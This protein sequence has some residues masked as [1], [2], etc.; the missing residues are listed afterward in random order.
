VGRFLVAAGERFPSVS[1]LL[2]FEF[3]PDY[4]EAARERLRGWLPSTEIRIEQGDFFSVDWSP[5]LRS[6]PDP[7]LVLGNPPWVTNA[8]LE[9]LG[10]SNLPL[11]SNTQQLRGI[12]AITG[13]S[14][15][16]ISEWMLIRELEWISDRD[17]ALAMLCKTAVAR[18]VLLHT[19]SHGQNP[20]TAAAYRIDA[21]SHFGA[22]VD[23]CLLV[24]CPGPRNGTH[25][26]RVYPN[27][28][29][30][31]PA[32][33]FGY[34]SGRLVADVAA[35]DR[36]AHLEG[37]DQFR[38]RSGIKHDCSK[39]MELTEDGGTYRN[40]MAEPVDIEDDYLFPMV[41]SADLARGPVSRPHRRML[42]TQR[43]VGEDTSSIRTRAPR[44]WKYLLDHADLLNR[45][46]SAVYRNRLCFSIFGVGDYSFAP[47]KVAISGFYRKLDFR[48][49]GPRD[50][51]PAV[52]DDTCY[53][54]ACESEQEAS[55]LA[56]LLNSSTAREFFSA[57]IFWDAKRPITVDL[58]RRLDLQK[59]AREMGL[60]PC[61]QECF[62]S[63]DQ[64]A[65]SG[66]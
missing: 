65:R 45:R 10:S 18:K 29:E 14:N 11:K 24:I 9:R 33:T 2:G 3:K 38:W 13:K 23:A 41:K 49:I 40:G 37:T 48:I 50:G 34:R 1:H 17:A 7:L 57:F 31:R 35:F 28:G 32:A 15:F 4:V 54:L 30:T 36:V 61:L 20:A 58:L 6:L 39:V 26:C 59:L 44:T 52:L 27:L 12:D 46:M 62:E 56:R 43:F 25:S 47:W 51:K 19:W 16:D 66:R 60:E 53:F 22:A 21:R 5:V 42:V 8:T 63:R 55:L 64:P